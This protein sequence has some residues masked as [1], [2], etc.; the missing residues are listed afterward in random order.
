MNHMQYGA[1][2]TKPGALGTAIKLT[3]LAQWAT[4]QQLSLRSGGPPTSGVPTR[5]EGHL[6]V[7]TLSD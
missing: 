1:Y 6:A 5:L 7:Q 4:E 2:K 3:K